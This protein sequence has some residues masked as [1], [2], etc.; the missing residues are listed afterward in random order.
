MNPLKRPAERP[1]T[2][3]SRGSYASGRALERILA[4]VR[5]HGLPKASSR[6]TQYRARKKAALT[7]TPHGALVQHLELPLSTGPRKFAVQHPMAMLHIARQRSLAFDSFFK[8]RLALH[9]PDQSPWR[10]VMYVDEVGHNPVG[11]DNRKCEAIYWSFL[12]FGARAL[13]TEDAWFEVMVIRT[14]EVQ[15]LPGFMSQLFV[16]LLTALFFNHSAGI[17][18]MHGVHLLDVL[19]FAKLA[20]NVADEKALKEIY[21]CKG[22]SGFRFAHVV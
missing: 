6:R 2:D 17:D 7:L 5:T 8:E 16:I 9:P 4:D 10:L 18:L 3:W 19:L 12:E 20:C 21:G 15:K 22:A 1:L 13:H 14:I 11:R